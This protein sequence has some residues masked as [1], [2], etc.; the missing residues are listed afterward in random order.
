MEDAE[1]EPSSENGGAG[2]QLTGSG[3]GEKAEKHTQTGCSP[4]AC[5]SPRET[6]GPRE[7]AEHSPLPLPPSLTHSESKS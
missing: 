5:G 2:E 1:K 4:E 7:A 3:T 6:S